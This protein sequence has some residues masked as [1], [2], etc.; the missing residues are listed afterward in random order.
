MKQFYLKYKREIND[1]FHYIL[2]FSIMYDIGVLTKFY[3]YTIEAKIIGVT[4][5]SILFGFI[6]SGVWEGTSKDFDKKDILRTATG[7]ALGGIVANWIAP[8]QTLIIVCN[9][10]SAMILVFRFTRKK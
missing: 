4:L 5:V 3:T 10:I 7:F 2:G 9:I 1:I 8:N 6:F